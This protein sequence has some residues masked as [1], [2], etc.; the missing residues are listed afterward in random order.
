[1]PRPKTNPYRK[2]FSFDILSN[3]STCLIKKMMWLV[4]KS[5]IAL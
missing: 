5:M 1:M 4:L 3:T 2:Y